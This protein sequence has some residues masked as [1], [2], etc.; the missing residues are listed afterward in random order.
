MERKKN[1]GKE[2]HVG[3]MRRRKVVFALGSP[4]SCFFLLLALS[5]GYAIVEI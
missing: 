5:G 3:L 4:I 2:L 1:E